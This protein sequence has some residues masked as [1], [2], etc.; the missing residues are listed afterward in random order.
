MCLTYAK[1]VDTYAAHIEKLMSSLK[2]ILV[3]DTLL[4]L[5]IILK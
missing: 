2:M 5:S 1:L 4:C 3:Q